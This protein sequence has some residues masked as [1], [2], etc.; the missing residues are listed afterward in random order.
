MTW[1]GCLVILGRAESLQ[2]FNDAAKRHGAPNVS[3]E[4]KMDAARLDHLYR[5]IFPK[6]GNCF[7]KVLRD[8]KGGG[9]GAS[10]P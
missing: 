9:V 2:R 6:L 4:I 1:H 5:A 8:G 3:I 7:C 10:G